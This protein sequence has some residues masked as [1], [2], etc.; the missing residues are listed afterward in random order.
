MGN[1]IP[2]STHERSR[3]VLGLRWRPGRLVLAILR[4][5]LLAYHHGMGW[6]LGHAFL[7]LT[8]RG[9]KTGEPH[10]TVAMV[11]RYQPEV[12]EAVISSV[13]GPDTDWMRNIRANPAS[14]V[15]IGKEVFTPQ[16]RFLSEPESV[17]VVAECLDKHP[18]RFRVV[19]FV[20]GWGNL[21]VESVAQDVVHTRPFVAFGPAPAAKA[22]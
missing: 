17:E 10:E 22:R 21:R 2:R 15:Q 5:P 18:W 7:L 8:H 9:R 3:P 13:W 12:S 1:S 19:A 4:M 16:Q 14:R 6:L 20:L 11:L